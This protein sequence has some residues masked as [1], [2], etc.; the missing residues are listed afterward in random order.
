VL[1][2]IAREPVPGVDQQVD[3]E[4]GCSCRLTAHESVATTGL[5]QGEKGAKEPFFQNYSA[6]DLKTRTIKDPMLM[7]GEKDAQGRRQDQPAVRQMDE[8]TLSVTHVAKTRRKPL[9]KDL[10]PWYLPQALGHLLPRLVPCTYLFLT[11][12]SDSNEVVNRFVDV[13]FEQPVELWRT[14]RSMRSRHR[15]HRLRRL[16]HRAL[17]YIGRQISLGSVE[18]RI[19]DHHPAFLTPQPLAKALEERQPYASRRNRNTEPRRRR[20]R[21]DHFWD[22]EG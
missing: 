5:L 8:Y 4:R 14:H 3:A 18:C 17:R 1:V 9:N 22:D 15:S 2:G 10:S 11:Y 12:V 13:G 20:R 19:K 7:P 16:A 21:L 6:S